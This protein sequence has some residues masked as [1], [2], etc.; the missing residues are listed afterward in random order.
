MVTCDETTMEPPWN[1]R[2]TTREP[3]NQHE[4][5]TKPPGNLFQSGKIY[6]IRETL[7]V[8]KRSNP[9]KFMEYGKRCQFRNGPIWENL[10]NTGNAV[11]SE[12]VQSE[13]IYGIR[14]MLSV[15]KRSNLGPACLLFGAFS[16]GLTRGSPGTKCFWHV[17][18][19]VANPHTATTTGHTSPAT[20]TTIRLGG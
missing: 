1:H 20:I 4:T 19:K 17:F 7:S 14:E 18:L 5:T 12:T 10:W 2:E 15:Q 6:G 11:S 9:G 3:W 8:Q 13:K 16:G